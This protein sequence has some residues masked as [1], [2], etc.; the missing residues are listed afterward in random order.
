[1][2]IYLF[3]YKYIYMAKNN[4]FHVTKKPFYEFQFRLIKST[5]NLEF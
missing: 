2:F 5:N 3:I 1:M 4:M